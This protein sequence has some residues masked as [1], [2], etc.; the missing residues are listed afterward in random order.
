MAHAPEKLGE[1]KEKMAKKMFKKG[2]LTK[3]S[4]GKGQEFGPQDKF[5]AKDEKKISRANRNDNGK[6]PEHSWE[7]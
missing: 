3:S 1:K 5:T 2:D 6:E 7:T 4:V